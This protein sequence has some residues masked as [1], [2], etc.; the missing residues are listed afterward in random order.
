LPSGSTSTCRRT[1]AS[2]WT[3]RL[4]H[5]EHD[6]LGPSDAA[7]D[8]ASDQWTVTIADRGFVLYAVVADPATVI[9]LRFVLVL[10]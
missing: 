3:Q 5:L 2:S 1:R 4:A 7:Y 8:P 10:E 6:P 9:V